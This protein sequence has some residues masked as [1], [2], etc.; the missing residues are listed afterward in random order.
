MPWHLFLWQAEG[1]PVLTWRFWIESY[2]TFIPATLVLVWIYNRSKGSI[3]VSGVYHAAANTA[4]AFFPPVDY[5]VFSVIM[6][7]FVLVIILVERMWKNLPSDR[8]AVVR[9]PVME[10]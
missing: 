9:E 10:S 7:I 1:Q 8:P 3:L 6:G 2:I 5:P 4:F